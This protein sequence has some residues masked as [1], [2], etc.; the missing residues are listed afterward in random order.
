[1][2]SFCDAFMLIG[3]LAFE[4]G[5]RK[6]NTRHGLCKIGID[7]KWEADIN[8]H[9]ETIDGVPPMHMMILFNG[10]PAGCFSAHGGTIAHGKIANEDALISAIKTQ[11]KEVSP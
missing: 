6:I 3:E 2:D 1:M 5:Y 11:L 7:D 9:K 10:M 8:P 4:R